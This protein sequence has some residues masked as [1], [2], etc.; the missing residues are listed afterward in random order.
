MYAYLCVPVGENKDGL[1]SAEHDDESKGQDGEESVG[2]TRHGR[3]P[4]PNRLVCT[5]LIL[6]MY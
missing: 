1:E 5:L 6:S 3:A 2:L 4:I